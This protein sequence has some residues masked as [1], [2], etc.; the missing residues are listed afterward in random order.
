MKSPAFIQRLV[1]HQLP[2]LSHTKHI[3][4]CIGRQQ[5][6]YT[7]FSLS[8]SPSW[9][10]PNFLSPAHGILRRFSLTMD[11]KQY[12]R[13]SGATDAVWVSQV[14]YSDAVKR[15]PLEDDTETEVC[16]IGAGITGLSTAYELVTRGKQVILAEARDVISGESGRTSGHLSNAL[17]DGYLEIEKKHGREGAKAA[18]ESHTWA[19]NHVGEVAK[20]LGIECQ[21]R[22]VPAYLISQYH[23]GQTKH[24]EDIERIAKEVELAQQLGVDAA[25][26]RDLKVKGWDGKPDQRGGAVFHGQAAFGPTAYL[27]GLRNWL[28]EQPNF[29]MYTGTRVVSVKEHTEGLMGT[30]QKSVE[31]Q[32]ESGKTIRCAH[33][34]EATNIPLQKLSVV[35]DMEYNRTYC[36]AIRVPKGSVEDCLLYDTADPY[37]YVRI[38]TCDDKDDY[39][40]VGGCDHQ[41]GHDDPAGRFEQL[42]KWTRERF[43]RAGRVDYRW[44]GQVMEPVDYVAFIGKNPAC[45]RIYIVSGDSGNG[46]THGV[47]AGRLIADE[48]DG[49]ANSW[50]NLYSPKRIQSLVKSAKDVVV[51]GI[52]V[53][54]K[55]KRLLQSDI[56][57]IEDLTPG[58]GGVLNP[59]LSKPTAIYKADD[60]TITKMS[61]LCPHMQGVVCWNAVEKSF[62]CP[63]HGSRFSAEGL[64]IQGP[65]KANLAPA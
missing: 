54:T 9:Y 12:M 49:T 60:G 27:V 2:V 58:C 8:N 50:V 52:Q 38:T 24:D 56:Q 62:D 35:V 20:K 30:G 17:D 40:I 1:S 61:A 45:E 19:L 37:I 10:T 39:L 18:A 33:A 47:L 26:D 21:Y 11:S 5:H 57:D 23:R 7:T 25:I 42:E 22:H 32:T 43:T 64:C 41:V 14:P 55:Y 53:N 13:T 34:V 51:H 6:L 59:T 28:L 48:I 15:C 16:I 31:I 29:R 3:G 65:A 36:I 4:L 46:L 63:V 44:S